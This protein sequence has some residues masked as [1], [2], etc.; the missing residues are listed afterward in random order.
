MLPLSGPAA[1]PRGLRRS[2]D[3]F[4][5]FRLEQSDPDL[6]YRAQADDSLAQAAEHIDPV[7]KLV[8]D[9]GG[10]AGWFSEAFRSAG[11]TCVLVEPEAGRPPAPDASAHA[12]A[13]HPGRLVPGWTVA[14][15]GNLMPFPDAAADLTFSSNVLEHVPDPARFLAEMVRVT[16]PGGLLYLS[17]TAWLS[18]W[19]GHET[20]PWHYLGGKRA[21][22]RYRRRHG[23]PPGNLYGTSLF[24]RYVGEVLRLVGA[25]ADL[26]VLVAG[27]RYY[28]R[29]LA[30]V[31]R[32]PGLRE[33]AT[34]NLLLIMRRRP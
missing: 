33:L 20:A 13:I 30:W 10:G 29:W 24:P 6:F 9:I 26:D 2:V 11:A 25:R 18:P 21:A 31:S 14:A 5:A 19:G 16:R 3:L 28:P 12:L 8:L 1:A 15:D 7:G 4:R 23:R 32:V 22:D 27:P 17:F 34:W